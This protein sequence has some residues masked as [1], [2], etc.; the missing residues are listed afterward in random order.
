MTGKKRFTAG[1]LAAVFFFV[2]LF[3]VC[4][5]A[6]ETH[7]DCTGENCMI[8]YQINACINTLKITVLALTAVALALSA[9]YSVVTA[10]KDDDSVSFD[11]TLVSL[12]VKLSN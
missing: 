12:K 1:V 7:H 3:S 11:T 4:Y 5:V 8:C 2:M 6:A 9:I 10:S